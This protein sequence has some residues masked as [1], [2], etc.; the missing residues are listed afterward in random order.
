[1]S[2]KPLN[3]NNNTDIDSDSYGKSGEQSFTTSSALLY[4]VQLQLQLLSQGWWKSGCGR[5]A[6]L[7]L[8]ADLFFSAWL[9]T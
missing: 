9:Q 2:Q 3:I 7:S 6:T 4:P 8:G 5:E 1:M